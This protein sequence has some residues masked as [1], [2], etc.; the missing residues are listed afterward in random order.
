[1]K[2]DSTRFRRIEEIFDGVVQLPKDQWAAALDR[3]CAADPMLREEVESLLNHAGADSGHSF[4]T[5]AFQALIP[6]SGPDANI[7]RRIGP[8]ELRRRL[9]GGGMG[10]VYLADQVEPVR[11]TVAIKL[12]K[13]GMDTDETLRRF[14]HERRV[15]AALSHPH[16]ARLL[17]AGSTDD[18]HPYFAMEYVEGEPITAYCDRHRLGIP[19]RLRLFQRV[20]TAVHFA[21][22][23]TVIHRD[24]KPANILIADD[25]SPRLLDFGIAKLTSPD[26]DAGLTHTHAAHQYMTPD[27]ASPEQIQGQIVT[28]ASDVYSLGVVLYEM[29]AG[30]RPFSRDGRQSSAFDKEPSRPSTGLRAMTAAQNSTERRGPA[31]EAIAEARNLRP[32]Q[33]IRHLSGDLDNIV[34]T[35]M[36]AEPQRRYASAEQLSAD[37]DRY[38]GH[39][40][41]LA[42]P[43]STLYRLRK[44]TRRNRTACVLIVAL[45]IGAIGST[46]GAVIAV[47]SRNVA[48]QAEQIALQHAEQLRRASYAQDLVF[49]SADRQR[50]SPGIVKQRLLDTPERLRDWE[51]YFLDALCHRDLQTWRGHQAAIK[52][53]TY[54][55][56]GRWVASGD[57]VGEIR[58]WDARVGT[59]ASVVQ[60]PR[61]PINSLSY[62]PTGRRLA[63]AGSD[64]ILRIRDSQNGTE[65][66][67][68]DG[69]GGAAVSVRFSP[70]GH[71]LAAG[72]ADNKIRLWDT[73]TG[74]VIRAMEGFQGLFDSLAFSP[75]GRLISGAS[76]KAGVCLWDAE[77]GSPMHDFG[78]DSRFVCST[79]FSPNGK[80]LAVA[81]HHRWIQL[82]DIEPIVRLRG[83]QNRGWTAS[84]SGVVFGPDNQRL[85]YVGREDRA[86]TVWD[87][88][89][90]ARFAESR[91]HEGRIL[92][93]AGSPDGK[94]TVTGG[95]DRTLKRWEAEPPSVPSALRGHQGGITCMAF[96]P[97]G[98][99]LATGDERNTVR[100]A[101][102]IARDVL[103]EVQVPAGH[104]R[105]MAFT[106]DGRNLVT[107]GADGTLQ[108][109]SA[110]TAQPL[111][112]ITAH[113]GAVHTLVADPARRV[114]A[115]GGEDGL[116]CLWNPDTSERLRTLACGQGAVGSIAFNH[117][118]SRLAIANAEYAI[119]IWNTDSGSRVQDLTGHQDIVRSVA[120]SRDGKWIASTGGDETVRIWDANTGRAVRVIEELGT[121]GLGVSF[122]LSGR[123]VFAAGADGTL[124]L[125]DTETGVRM[126]LFR[127][128]TGPS[129]C[130]ALS[131][132]GRIL[133]T[134]G[135]DRTVVIKDTIPAAVRTE[136]AEEEPVLAAQ[137][138]AITKDFFGQYGDWETI[139]GLFNVAYDTPVRLRHKILDDI[140]KR[141]AG[142]LS[143]LGEWQ[144]CFFNWEPT[145]DL[146]ILSARWFQAASTA[147]RRTRAAAI[148]FDWNRL[149]PA[150]GVPRESFGMVATATCRTSAGRYRLTG[151]VDD[152]VRVWIDERKVFDRWS[153]STR[154][155]K[156]FSADVAL[157][158]GEHA[159]RV[160]Y[161]QLNAGA[162]LNLSVQFLG[163]AAA[164]VD[165][166]PEEEPES[167]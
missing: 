104:P 71:D 115:S 68:L 19:Q 6:D 99:I 34:L 114:L 50:Y 9:G 70:N 38:L 134:G 86:L 139:A 156:T 23:N 3:L 69:H 46:G 73:N 151:S 32:E 157:A 102:P 123:R 111:K 146:A 112:M 125:W 165:T 154:R 47:R 143:P 59:T 162:F 26:L 83:Q 1:M 92:A 89:H 149:P 94:H 130:L 37:I 51:W 56:D 150:R 43:P 4:L 20:C 78:D 159:F 93:L 25:G 127:D 148:A 124:S 152:G 41:V 91:G 144:V 95:E 12:I 61:N 109:Y 153:I 132:D 8:Y 42:A 163:Q 58:V 97:D 63:S 13:R 31:I 141:T 2:S 103:R 128:H 36:A 167:E 118:G 121:T 101:T 135:T 16:I 133:A 117:D 82:W 62:D 55:P 126:L 17:D 18:G 49:V 14:D 105:C 65:L 28:T 166:A 44:F 110:F 77:T 108:V 30:Q 52:A 10:N 100:F 84:S 85:T 54:S 140:L 158:E 142:T 147:T 35:A 155:E 48:R 24:L 116:V 120:F 96:T 66:A 145:S 90:K 76:T 27:Y 106:A 131:P 72:Y 60:G 74:T 53:I 11:R 87:G 107:G 136:L 39:E 21:H 122:S 29:L 164:A 119:Q 7:G 98:R 15:L 57:T 137:V 33:L 161:F 5:Q 67:A 22:Q 138:F 81:V 45:L 113:A 129:T 40:P 75:N 79:T 64:G 88:V 160:E 80:S